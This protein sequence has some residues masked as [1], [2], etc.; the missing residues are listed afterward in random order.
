VIR[1]LLLDVLQ[2]FL[3]VLIARALLSWFPIRPG[4]ALATVRGGLVTVTEPVLGPV[5]RV[6]PRAGMFDLSFLVVFFGIT[7]LGQLIAN[8]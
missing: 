5:R 3:F 7:I 6:I 4:T 2:I 8:A 1:T